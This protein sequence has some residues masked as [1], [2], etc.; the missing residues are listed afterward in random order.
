MPF[1]PAF[2]HGIMPPLRDLRGAAVLKSPGPASRQTRLHR[3]PGYFGHPASNEGD[4][5][6]DPVAGMGFPLWL[7]GSVSE[8]KDLYNPGTPSATGP[9]ER[10]SSSVK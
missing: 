1:P 9:R 10:L 7:D 3:K 5:V 8:G 4:S 2:I 6:A